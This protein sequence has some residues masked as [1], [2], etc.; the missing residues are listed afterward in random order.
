MRIRHFLTSFV[1]ALMVLLWVGC[2]KQGYPSGGPKDLNAPV[3]VGCTPDNGSKNFSSK[4]FFIE[5]DEYVVL[6]DA[7]NNILVSPPMKLKPVFAT[8]GRGVMVTIKDSLLPNTTYLFQFKNAIADFTEGNLL[9][10]LEYVF[11]TGD[12]IDSHCVKGVVIDAMQ[13]KPLESTVSVLAYSEST[14]VSDSVVSSLKPTYVTR[15]D[16][17]GLFQL[18]HMKEGRY[19]IVALH[20]A[21]RNLQF[22][23]GESFAWVDSLVV[24]F[25]MPNVDVKLGDSL[26]VADSANAVQ[27]TPASISLRIS[28]LEHQVQRVVKS[29]MKRTGYAEIVTQMPLCDP[30]VTADAIWWSLNP[31]RDT[32][33]IWS[34]DSR[35]D[36][37]HIVLDDSASN[38]SDTLDIKYKKPKR[39]AISQNPPL[40]VNRVSSQHPYFDTLW[41][42]FSNPVLQPPAGDSL[43]SVM[44]LADS[45]SLFCGLSFVSPL[46]AFIRFAPKAGEKYQFCLPK[47]TC[48]DLYGNSNDT[49]R[50]ATEV[51]KPDQYGNLAVNLHRGSLGVCAC[52]VQ[53][54]DE[55]DNVVY[56]VRTVGSVVEFKN[57]KPAKY[58]VRC[59]VDSDDDGKWTP[60]DYWIGRQPEQVFYFNK[61][62]EVRANW[63]I[64]ETWHLL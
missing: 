28:T 22:N 43:V 4:E 52:I 18:N 51:T 39:G 54:L 56:S 21:D 16:S 40:V 26:A 38:L 27:D 60:G 62:I 13:L 36:S 49:L 2:A 14:A 63:D 30:S 59:L 55:K 19:K 5:F 33:R 3:K 42:S 64:V 45:S 50:F 1:I 15:C 11:S 25:P 29:E 34:F 57:L 17:N 12:S 8:K 32:L 48:R 35:C 53:L 41:L 31:K 6:K 44:R 24:S 46:K 10:N 58:R 9:P 20:D 37:L 47:G 23:P 7:D 61:T